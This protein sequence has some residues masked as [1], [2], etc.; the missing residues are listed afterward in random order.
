MC[1]SADGRLAAFRHVLQ[2]SGWLRLGVG[3]HYQPG[4]EGCGREVIARGNTRGDA[5]QSRPGD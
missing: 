4:F 1:F 3:M 2:S 5:E